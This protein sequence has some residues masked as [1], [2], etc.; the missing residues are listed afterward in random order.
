[1]YKK[2]FAIAVVALSSLSLSAI[3]QGRPDDGKCCKGDKQEQSSRPNFDKKDSKERMNPFQGITLTT[4]QQAKLDNLRKKEAEQRDKDKEKMDKERKE[5]ME[6]HDKEVK[7]ILT[8]AQYQQYEANKQAMKQAG[9]DRKNDKDGRVGKRGNGSKGDKGMNGK[10]GRN[11]KPNRDGKGNP[12][13]ASALNS[14]DKPGQSDSSL[15]APGK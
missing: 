12:N 6:K 4:D 7:K 9:K 5:R 2:I 11:G 1:M 10:G 13:V 8:T 14:Y 3:A 15:P